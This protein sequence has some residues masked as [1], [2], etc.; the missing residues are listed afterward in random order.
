MVSASYKLKLSVRKRN[1]NILDYLL[2]HYVL[3]VPT[4]T[5]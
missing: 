2:Y 1:S 5:A 3:Y 4:I